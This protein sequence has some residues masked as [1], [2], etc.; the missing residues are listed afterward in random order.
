MGDTANA[1]MVIDSMD[2]QPPMAPP[3]AT[4]GDAEVLEILEPLASSASLCAID[5]LAWA[6]PE[7]DASAEICF[8]ADPVAAVPRT[9]EV[10]ALPSVP[11]GPTPSAPTLRLRELLRLR[12][13]G[14]TRRYP[15][16]PRGRKPAR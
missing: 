2:W 14:R 6:A 16:R 10:P 7:D 1:A 4:H 12:S 13:G 5:V 11:V 3:P 8:D 9:D 15:G